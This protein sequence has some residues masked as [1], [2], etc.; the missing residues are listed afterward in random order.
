MASNKP[1]PGGSSLPELMA[2]YEKCLQ[3]EKDLNSRIYNTLLTKY[4]NYFKKQQISTHGFYIKLLLNGFGSQAVYEEMEGSVDTDKIMTTLLTS[5]SNN[6]QAL[7]DMGLGSLYHSFY[8]NKKA[9]NIKFAEGNLDETKRFV[10]LYKMFNKALPGVSIKD[11]APKN[12]EQSVRYDMEISLPIDFNNSGLGTYNMYLEN[13]TGVTNSALTSS[14]HFGTI[15]D[16]AIGGG[17][18]AYQTFITSIQDICHDYI[19]NITSHDGVEELK[20]IKNSFFRQL[21]VEYIKWR[22]DNYFPVYTSSRRYNTVL[23][24]EILKCMIDGGYLSLDGGTDAYKEPG[25]TI[26]KYVESSS[27]KQTTTKYIRDASGKGR[28]EDVV[29]QFND[30]T[31]AT[32]SY[33]VQPTYERV[34][35]KI[36]KDLTLVSPKFKASLW[37]GKN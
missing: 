12:F 36:K 4:H 28:F 13:K 14:F 2:L 1:F 5:I 3:Y 31:G 18:L 8:K 37:Y 15:S 27:Y 19:S 35:E 26:V 32:R 10:S 30:D 7:I 11:T 22:L 24:S 21:I 23:C 29:N 25:K 34:I 20:K 17:D 9:K 33:A 6:P 16:S